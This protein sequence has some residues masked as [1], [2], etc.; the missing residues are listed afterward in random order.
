MN[1]DVVVVGGGSAECIV[2][3]R[4]S[5]DPSRSVMLL[6]AGNGFTDLASCPEVLRSEHT[7][8]PP[9]EY[10]WRYVGDKGRTGG[11]PIGVIRGALPR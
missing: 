3:S 4:L 10:T 9:D 6:E 5:E 2:A 1:V 11:P 8:L 7:V